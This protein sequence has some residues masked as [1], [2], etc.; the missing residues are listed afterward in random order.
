MS[1]S[2]HSKQPTWKVLESG[3]GIHSEFLILFL[4]LEENTSRFVE[5]FGAAALILVPH[6]GTSTDDEH[7]C[8]WSQGG[9][10]QGCEERHE[11]PTGASYMVWISGSLSSFFEKRGFF[12]Q[13][14][15][16]EVNDAERWGFTKFQDSFLFFKH[17]CYAVFI[18]EKARSK[19][20][21]YPCII[22]GSSCGLCAT[23]LA[24]PWAD[25]VLTQ[26]GFALFGGAFSLLRQHS[27]LLVS[28]PKI[29][30]R[31]TICGC[32]FSTKRDSRG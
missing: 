23:D 3:E 25:G 10:H 16:L 2:L 18:L 30:L 14:K 13:S 12:P 4:E 19:T 24:Q 17:K 11:S 22:R 6:P 20:L 26:M 29:Q 21:L 5:K 31:T 32:E 28:N 7:D 8:G 9:R 1:S 27:H 15:R